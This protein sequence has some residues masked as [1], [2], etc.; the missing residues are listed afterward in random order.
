MHLIFNIILALAVA[1]LF[2]LG[3]WALINKKLWRVLPFIFVAMLGI[4]TNVIITY[5]K[6]I[7]DMVLLWLN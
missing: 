5:K 1:K 4:I 2:V 6:F 3:I 7:V